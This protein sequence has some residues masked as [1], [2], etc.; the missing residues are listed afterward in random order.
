MDGEGFGEMTDDDSDH[1]IVSSSLGKNKS[2]FPAWDATSAVSRVS[3]DTR[4]NLSLFVCLCN[5]QGKKDM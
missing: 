2:N 1:I 5:K 4:N 3:T